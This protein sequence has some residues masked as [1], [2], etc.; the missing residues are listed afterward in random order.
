MPFILPKIYPILD[1]SFI[2]QNNREEFLK[3]L[4]GGLAE[5]GLTLLEYRH[6]NGSDAEI[7]ADAAILRA[8]LSAP[9][10]KLILDDRVDLIGEAGFDGVHVD[11]GD[12]SPAEAR[13]LLGPDRIIGTFG[14][15]EAFLP[16]VLD[17]PVDY[18]AVGPAYATTTKQTTKAPIGPEGVRKLRTL[19]GSERVL[20]TAG[21]IT[22]ATAPLLL[23]AG[24]TSVAV[25]SALFGAPDPV[26]VFRR[27]KAELG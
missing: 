2:P 5:A 13:R 26:A 10:F 9:H 8:A 24:A 4:A 19:A 17:A 21:G 15:S 22:L 3:R 27:W 1:S 12:L 6:K 14:G 11:D 23:A 7:V 20:T 16:G 25:A 18:W